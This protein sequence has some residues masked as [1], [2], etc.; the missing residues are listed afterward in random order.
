M[1]TTAPHDVALN[2]ASSFFQT[3]EPVDKL[4]QCVDPVKDR[5]LWVRE[6][7]TGEIRPVNIEI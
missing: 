1:G 3:M 6:N 5:E 4:L 7:K 2:L